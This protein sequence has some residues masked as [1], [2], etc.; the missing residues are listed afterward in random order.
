VSI[1]SRIKSLFASP[2]YSRIDYEDAQRGTDFD[3]LDSVPAS[4]LGGEMPCFNIHPDR[5][6]YSDPKTPAL[7]RKD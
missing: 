1:W 2:C 3:E 7:Y 4:D 5:L 6:D